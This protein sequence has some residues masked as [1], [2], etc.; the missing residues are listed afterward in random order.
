[1]KEV[2]S[3]TQ[4]S[5]TSAEDEQRLIESMMGL[6]P[7]PR[8]LRLIFRLFSPMRGLQSIRLE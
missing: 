3:E 5:E 2:E 4:S 6:R 7:R 1:M 8:N